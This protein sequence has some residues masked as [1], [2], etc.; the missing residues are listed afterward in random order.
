MLNSKAVTKIQTAILITIIAISAA[1]GAATYY[2]LN[3]NPPQNPQPTQTPTPSTSPTTSSTPTTHGTTTNPTMSI[4]PT[5]STPAKTSTITPTLQPKEPIKIGVCADTDSTYGTAMV[6]GAMLAAEQIN[7]A[8]GLLGRNLTVVSE[9]DDSAT[10]SGD[11]TVATNAINKL[12]TEDKADFLITFGTFSIMYQDICSTQKKIH[13]SIYDPNENL[14]QRVIDNY[15]KYK[16]TFRAEYIANGTTMNMAHVQTL[17]ALRNV[18][19][20]TKVGYLLYDGG[21][22]RDLTV[23]NFESELPKLG[24]QIVYRALFAPST[25]DFTSYFA[26][27]EAAKTQILFVIEASPSGSTS[28]V[29]EWNNRHSP[30]LLCGDLSGVTLTSFWNTTSGNTAFVLSKSTGLSINYPITNQTAPARDA[31][32]A[33]WGVGLNGLSASAYDVVE[34]FLADA[35]TRAGTTDTDAVIKSLETIKIDTI[36]SNDFSFTSNHDIYVE[37]SGMMNL[38]KTTMLYI[39]VQ[40]QNG[41]QVPIFPD[42][43]RKAVGGSLQYPPWPGPWS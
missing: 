39:V 8:G 41:V 5:S 24:Y 40:W 2:L 27:A 26:Q 11:I 18:T 20:F 16:Y 14:T 35:I 7:V 29:K 28:I 9:D 4:S 31:F 15:D 19:G 36:L 3:S 38:S 33:R 25:M 22:I 12:I 13:F 23:P 17:A 43:L 37:A 34:F 10:G 1:S 21:T 32:F 6:Q 42:S 30:M